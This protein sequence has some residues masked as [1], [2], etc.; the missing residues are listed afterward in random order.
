MQ[1]IPRPKKRK[2]STDKM[3]FTTSTCKTEVLFFPF[4]IGSNAIIPIISKEACCW[5]RNEQFSFKRCYL[6]NKSNEI[7]WHC[8][9]VLTKARVYT[10][11]HLA[12]PKGFNL[13]QNMWIIFVM[14]TSS[15]FMFWYYFKTRWGISK[16]IWL[17]II[18]KAVPYLTFSHKKQQNN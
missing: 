2:N 12:D 8:A 15:H 14:Q 7:F 10:I 11:L 18:N 5:F 1:C 17:L 16:R 6:Y 3:N 4:L 9:V 13:L